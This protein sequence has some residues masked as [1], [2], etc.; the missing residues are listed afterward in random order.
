LIS[1][2]WRIWGAKNGEKFYFARLFHYLKSPIILIYV[3]DIN[4]GKLDFCSEIFT[5][6]R[7]KDL[8]IVNFNRATTK[9]I[10][11]ISKFKLEN[12][13]KFKAR[14]MI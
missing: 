11:A 1:R 14:P 4:L 8:V 13:V 2:R 5:K 12:E 9:I 7:E 3:Q 10:C 6:I